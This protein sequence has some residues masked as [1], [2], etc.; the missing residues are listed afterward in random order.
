MQNVKPVFNWAND[1]WRKGGKSLILGES[2]ALY[3]SLNRKHEKLFQI[4]KGQKSADWSEDEINLAAS[5]SDFGTC[6]SDIANGMIENIAFQWETD[7]MIANS[8]IP[9]LA[10]FITDS[11]FATTVSKNAEIERLNILLNGKNLHVRKLEA[12][13][14]EYRD[15]PKIDL[16]G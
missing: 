10:P 9:L 13:L 16:R 7:S 5:L 4:Y 2:P 8:M 14:K 6:P 3:D 12:A 11:D 1:E 15:R